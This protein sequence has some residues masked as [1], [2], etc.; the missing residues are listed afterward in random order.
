MADAHRSVVARRRGGRSAWAAAGGVALLAHVAW[1]LSDDAVLYFSQ[2]YLAF[3]VACVHAASPRWPS[4]CWVAC[5]AQV[6]RIARDVHAGALVGRGTSANAVAVAAL[7]FGVAVQAVASLGDTDSCAV[8]RGSHLC[9]LAGAGVLLAGDDA[10][11]VW[12]AAAYLVLYWAA[13][14]RLRVGHGTAVVIGR[15]A[16]RGAHGTSGTGQGRPN[17]NTQNIDGCVMATR[18]FSPLETGR[19]W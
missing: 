2:L 12:C 16:V 4:L 15:A 13:P 7:G 5:A 8:W 6:P 19:L 14:T 11:F 17:P 1:H 3:L 18:T 10:T 9:V